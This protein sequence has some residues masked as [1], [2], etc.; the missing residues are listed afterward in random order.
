MPGPGDRR[1]RSEA[2]RLFIG[3]AVAVL[4]LIVVAGVGG[5]FLIDSLGE[6]A[7]GTFGPG[8]GLKGAAVI[9]FAISFVSVVVMA[10][11]SGGDAILG[12]LPFTLLGFFVFFL[13]CWLMLAWIF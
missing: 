12:E 3:V 4:L 9:A 7:Q 10:V 13:F 1:E 5:Y 8:L 11:V 6:W 2:M